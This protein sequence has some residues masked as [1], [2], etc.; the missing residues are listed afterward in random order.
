MTSTG[1]KISRV[2]RTKEEAKRTYDRVSRWYDPFEGIWERRSIKTGLEKLSIK[3]GETV[4]EIGFGTGHG[5]LYM[6]ES[7]GET[8]KVYGI[9]ISPEML[10]ITQARLNKR[11]LSDRVALICGDAVKLPFGADFFDAVFMSFV[12]ELFDTP[13]IPKILSECKRVLKKGGRI[14]V[15]SISKLGNFN[16]IRNLYEWGHEKFPR[17]LDCRPIYVQKALE[18]AKFEMDLATQGSLLGLP[19]EIVLAEKH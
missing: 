3:K 1:H 6:A 10:N 2:I 11:G 13:E 9:D 19:V 5:M 12:L 18:E 8:G 7:V 17:V 15:V 4:L 16:P 14:C